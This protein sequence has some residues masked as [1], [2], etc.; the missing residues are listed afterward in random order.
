MVVC[1]ADV[2]Q[3]RSG[4]LRRVGGTADQHDREESGG[5]TRLVL[6]MAL[7][8]ASV[9]ATAGEVRRAR[10][11]RA[12]ADSYIVVLK[13]SA[14]AAQP[15]GSVPLVARDLAARHGGRL[16]HVYQHALRGFAVRLGESAARALAEDAR[17]DY[18]EPDVEMH[19]D[20]VQ[21]G[22]PWGLDR[23]D[24][25]DLPLSGTY[26]TQGGGAGVNVYVVDTGIRATH[27]EFG[28]RARYAFSA[29]NDGYG[30]TDCHGHGTHVSGT[31]A[32][33]TAGVAKA[34]TV[35]AVRVLD[36]AGTGP[37][38][39]SIAGVDW[40]AANHIKPAVAN[41]S[42]GGAVSQALD[43]AIR[44]AV[45]A[46]VTFVVSAG[47][48]NAD[49]CQQSPARVLEAITVGASGTVDERASF[50]NW[51]TCVDV[52]APGVGILSSYYTSDTAMG[53]L[54]G[55]SM[56]S[57]H[58]AGVAA[59]Y[60]QTNPGA[61]PAAVASAV[62]GNATV[63]KVADPGTG[64]PNR[65]LYSMFAPAAGGPPCTGCLHFTGTLAGTGARQIQ[66][67]GTNYWTGVAGTH[68]AW[69][70]G[71]AG[72]NF[73]LV[74]RYYTGSAWVVVAKS[75]GTSSTESISYDG[76]PGTYQWKIKSALGGGDYDFW[77]DTP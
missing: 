68:R 65:L 21:S 47:N 57:P 33:A 55:T 62:L 2:V 13:E 20:N 45:A 37:M 44:R 6:T 72:T 63:G 76:P 43:D 28:G 64:S 46:G 22:A 39:A 53:A 32:G 69:L 60:L 74:L 41:M 4:D 12:I 48:A 11:G 10:G 7:A 54:S 31:I 51:G 70:R 71:P 15:S 8:A 40:V 27:V 17:V 67:Y 19:L 9:T 59:V 52:F 73:N 25:R 16:A 38:S 75:R 1:R 66:P 50:S 56:A 77:I 61:A 36:C 23:T 24:Q 58:V 3:R 5:M 49:A 18:V 35:W 42:L 30:A 14:D 26:E 29:I 34:A